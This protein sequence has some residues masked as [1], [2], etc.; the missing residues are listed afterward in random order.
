MK[1]KLL[2][3]IISAAVILLTLQSDPG[4]SFYSSILNKLQTMSEGDFFIDIA[5]FILAGL[6]IIY[7]I[8][9]I[10]MIIQ[11]TIELL[12]FNKINMQ[13]TKF[14]NIKRIRE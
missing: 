4:N 3:L 10:E 2:I 1:K 7:I 8:K 9:I 13:K 14:H 11:L 6:L 12:I 5:P